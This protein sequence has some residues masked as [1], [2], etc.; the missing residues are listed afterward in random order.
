MCFGPFDFVEHNNIELFNIA[1]MSVVTNLTS[2]SEAA[3][4][5]LYKTCQRLKQIAWIVNKIWIT[6]R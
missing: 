5:L 4:Y 1:H 6:Y 2:V 3:W